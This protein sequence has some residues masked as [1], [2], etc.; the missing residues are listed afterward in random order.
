MLQQAAL[1]CCSLLAS[2]RRPVLCLLPSPC[3]PGDARPPPPAKDANG[4]AANASAGPHRDAR[5][6]VEQPTLLSSINLL[7]AVVDLLDAFSILC[8]DLST[9]ALPLP[10]ARLL[11]TAV[12]LLDTSSSLQGL[13]TWCACMKC[14]PPGLDPNEFLRPPGP[15]PNE[16][17]CQPPPSPPPSNGGNVVGTVS[18]DT[19]RR[20][21]PSI[22]ARK[23]CGAPDLRP[24]AQG[25][26][27]IPYCTTS[28]DH[29]TATDISLHRPRKKRFS[30]GGSTSH[31]VSPYWASLPSII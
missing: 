20:W 10:F 2:A 7:V 31:S 18:A 11:L 28:D 19:T 25:A 13:Q 1:R 24:E 30:C 5:F 3:P 6:L 29:N 27:H 17:A 21:N 14:R 22:S 23:F 9:Y 4:R 16:T 12:V 26:A 15:A 8:A